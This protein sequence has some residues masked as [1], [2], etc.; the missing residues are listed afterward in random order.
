M[1]PFPR[2]VLPLLMLACSAALA[3][4]Y[5]SK[6]VRMININAPGGPIDILGRL[7]SDR[8]SA[9]LGQPFITDN[10][11]SA[12]G[13]VA[14]E[15][16]L[17]SP[18]DGYTFLFGTTFTISTT[19]FM[20]TF[21][22]DIE[23]EFVPVALAVRIPFVVVVPP[24]SPA[25]NLQDLQQLA[26]SKGDGFMTGSLGPSTLPR[27][28]LEMLRNAARLGGT[29]V[30]YKAS[31]QVLQDV[32]NGSLDV[33]VETL[34]PTIPFLKGNRV[35]A[36]AVTTAKRTELAPDIPALEEQGFKDSESIGS[37]G[38]LAASKT[39]QA[40]IDVIA[41]ETVA[42]L[43]EP[44]V[45]S[46]LISLGFIPDPGGPD[47]MHAAIMRERSQYLPIVKALNLRIDQ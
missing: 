2:F 28:T 16:V 31:P 44:E 13:T 3:Q 24:N 40:A 20:Y 47:K 22:F 41:R 26:K 1:N 38:I 35:R 36:L 5:P 29:F 43:S 19:Q 21:P 15:A 27:I 6:P 30:P 18:A 39:P 14:M 11:P 42:A 33:A 7:V 12:V 23:K 17:K 45:R 9:R 25:R 34:G 32:A 46:R 4:P 10:R 8:L 37:L